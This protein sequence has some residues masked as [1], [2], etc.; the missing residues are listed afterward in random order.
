VS[1]G[2]VHL[3]GQAPRGGATVLV[4]EARAAMR[5]A[6]REV[7]HEVPGVGRAAAAST[8]EEA[9]SEAERLRP[10]VAIVA[11]DLDG[12]AIAG[13]TAVR[14]SAPGC[15]IAL[16][17]SREDKDL[18]VRGL[19]VGARAFVT[20]RGRL[21]ELIEA[22]TALLDGGV[23]VPPRLMASALDDLV[24]GAPARRTDG[25]LTRLTSREREVLMLLSDGSNKDDIA[26]RLFISPQ[27]AR[28]HLQNIFAKLGAR[29]KLE[30][31]ALVTEEDRSTMLASRRA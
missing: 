30:A 31:I 19:R 3:D 11:E 6:L 20:T 28:T 7:L 12:G 18:L 29:S 16:L 5:D 8:V 23:F 25:I 27:T 21:S 26:R 15:G 9:G 13:A 10:S 2:S 1:A 14:L 4:C 17:A 24:M 22:V